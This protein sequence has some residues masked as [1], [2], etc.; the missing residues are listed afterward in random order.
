[1]KKST[2]KRNLLKNKWIIF[3]ATVSF[4]TTLF[5]VFLPV[6]GKFYLTRWLLANGA[7][8]AVIKHVSINPFSG[9]ASLKGVGITI[10]G[11]TVL[12]NAEFLVNIGMIPILKKEAKLEEVILSDVTLDIQLYKDGQMRLASYTTPSPT[13][14]ED[15][16]GSKSTSFSWIILAQQVTMSNCKIHFEMPDLDITVQVDDAALHH[17]TT[18]PEDTSGTISLNGSVNGT[19]IALDIRSLGIEPDLFAKGTVKIDDFELNNLGDFLKSY[20]E[21]FTGLVSADG[22]ALF[23]MTESGDIFVDYEGM[24]N[25]KNGHIASDSFSVQGA[26]VRWNKGKVHFELTEQKGIIIDL[27]GSLT[28]KDIEVDIPDP[29][30]KIKEPDVAINGK[31]LVIINNEVRINTCAGFTLKHTTFSMPPLQAEASN[32]RW[33][34]KEQCIQ[35]NSGTADKELSV[36]VQ[37][38]LLADTPSFSDQDET[39]Q[40]AIS[41]SSLSLNGEASYLLGL[42]PEAPSIVQ[43]RGELSGKK[44]SLTLS[45]ILIY[46]QETLKAEGESS[47]RLAS[48]IEVDYI[49]NLALKETEL[50]VAGVNSS[51]EEM[52]WAK[53]KKG[54]VAFTLA[55]DNSMKIALD[56]KLES[57]SLNAKLIETGLLFSQ[58]HMDITAQGVVTTGKDITIKGKSSLSLNNFTLTKENASVPLVSVEGFTIDSLKAPGGKKIQIKQARA[59]GVN[60]NLEGNMPSRTTIS[61]INLSD[62][63]TEDLST[64]STSKITAQS[65]VMIATKNNKNL[66]GLGS[67]EIHDIKAG[68]GQQV[69]VK[70]VNFDDFFFLGKAAE[71][72]DSTCHIKSTRL[73]K[74]GWNPEKGIYG[75]SLSLAGLFCTLTREKDGS[76]TMNKQLASMSL[77]HP[78]KPAEQTTKNGPKE[79]GIKFHLGQLTL[80]GESGIHFEDHTLEVPFTGDL[81]IAAL[82]IENLHSGEPDNA[83]KV[84]MTGTL[85]KRAPLK[86]DGTIAPF[87]DPLATNL[88]INIKNYPLARLSPY[89]VQS[90]GVALAKG[91]LQS[92]S[93]IILNGNI[94]DMENDVLLKKLETSTI[95]KELADTLD[96]QLPIPLNSAL[97]VLRDKDD[98]ISLNIPIKGQID[99]L[100]VGISDILITALGKAIVPAAS[101]Y[102][103]YVLG[104]YGALAYVGMKI[105][106]KILEIKLPPVEF[107]PGKT[108]LP[109]DIE[110]YLSRLAQILQDHPKGDLQLCPQSSA[111]E[112]IAG[113][114]KETLKKEELELNEK[115]KEKLMQLGQERAQ[116]IKDYMIQKFMI[117]KNRLLICITDI[118]TD[119]AVKPRVNIQ[120]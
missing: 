14:V 69:A 73:S 102:L 108:E 12:S 13:P 88:T 26:P 65:P 37:G 55:A 64:F 22:K 11:S 27:D 74:F 77:P 20:L 76:F 25:L 58:Q 119:K 63:H 62:I 93:N 66:A 105:G 106:E 60:V 114:T 15:Q 56:G 24:I 54:S 40:L 35:F 91:E 112:F 82:Q 21:P 30:I 42:T 101:G 39:I 79:P 43:T 90:V 116:S 19:P 70:R 48:A 72:D 59:K 92:Q 120:M 67:L 18:A 84:K 107:S 99:E 57:K 68:P 71:N 44:L 34:G 81:D 115:E 96:N 97:S 87:A 117:D 78:D 89:T 86:V 109:G 75:D 9:K 28:G 49:G 103:M 50:Q 51:A 118:G 36:R 16:P 41:G 33:Q 6:A 52:T 110:D 100:N 10:N 94:L 31:V 17:I 7:D 29:V 104:P 2:L 85:A 83:T 23:K 4:F 8:S 53:N 1:M 32:I 111:W 80:R 47:V 113:T 38:E 95:S 5:L 61:T 3:I 98:N 46:K 45:D